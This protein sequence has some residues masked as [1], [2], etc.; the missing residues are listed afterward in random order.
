MMEHDLRRW[1]SNLGPAGALHFKEA[2]GDILRYSADLVDM[3]AWLKKHT[4]L[5]YSVR[6]PHSTGNYDRWAFGAKVYFESSD[7]MTHF[8]IYWSH[9]IK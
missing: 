5:R 2:D 7:D 4:T 6:P 1:N 9:R 3:R 8:K